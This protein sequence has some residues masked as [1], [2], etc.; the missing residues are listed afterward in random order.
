MLDIFI[1]YAKQDRP[2]AEL[3]AAKL[4]EDGWQVLGDRRIEAG[5]PWK[6]QRRER[7]RL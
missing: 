1:S 7:P 6:P 4:P 2:K 5:E 3:L